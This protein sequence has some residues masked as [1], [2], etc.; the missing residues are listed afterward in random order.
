LNLVRRADLTPSACEA[1]QGARPLWSTVPKRDEFGKPLSDFMML[2][3][4]LKRRS[5]HEI[6]FVLDTIRTELSRFQDVIVFAD[7]NLSLNLLWV[8]LRARHGAMSLIVHALRKRLP[9]L[10]LVG[11]NP[12]PGT[13]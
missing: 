8:S 6:D 7:F 13:G 1:W 11:H 9:E 4:G 3:P 5:K 12:I 10:K 2:L